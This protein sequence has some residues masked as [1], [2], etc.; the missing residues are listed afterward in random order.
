MNFPA[1]QLPLKYQRKGKWEMRGHSVHS[2]LNTY[3]K[4]GHNYH[5]HESGY[6]ELFLKVGLRGSLKSS[7]ALQQ[8]EDRVT[9]A[10][11]KAEV[12]LLLSLQVWHFLS[13]TSPAHTH[14][15]VLPALNP[16]HPNKLS[17][18]KGL[19]SS[20]GHFLALWTD[21]Q[22]KPDSF[23]DSILHL[24]MQRGFFNIIHNQKKNKYSLQ[25]LVY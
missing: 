3:M 16:Q 21:L 13:K 2:S 9:K 25:I 8:I 19:D 15:S 5:E 6:T 7:W 18:V 4:K 1:F 12:Q 14:R 20:I 17:L 23:E 22:F 10:R 24:L 11:W